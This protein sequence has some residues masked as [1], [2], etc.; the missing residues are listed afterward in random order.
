MST[1]YV[2]IDRETPMLLPP[3]LRDW[4]PE[5][6]LVNFI[7]EAVAMLPL[8][9]FRVN[10]RGSGN[11]QY[12]PS[13]MLSLLI[14]CYATG[15]MGSRQIEAA[16]YTDV[17]VRYI[18][19][20]HAHPDHDTIC[21][22]RRKNGKLFEDSFVKVLAYAQE[23]GV[24]KKR[25]GVSV[26]GTKIQANASKHAAVSY[27]RAG[28]MIAQLEM[29]VQELIARAEAA[30]RTPVPEALKVPEE[31]ARRQVRQA[32]LAEAR[33]VIEA[34]FEEKRQEQ[35]S[36]YEAKQAQR[37]TRRAQ[38]QP[39]RGREPQ[40]PPTAPEAGAQYNFT[41]PESRIM[42]AGNGD[43]FEQAYNAQAVVDT[44]GSMLVLGA[45]VTEQANDK[46]QLV[47]TVQ[48][49]APVVRDV[50]EVL[51]DSGFF[52]E[53]AV[54]QI[55]ANEGPTVYAAMDKQ[56]HHRT[57]ADLVPKADPPVPSAD[58]SMKEKMR[59][60]LQTASGKAKYALRKQTV[61]PVFGII[62]AVMGFRR[63]LL[64][65]KIKVSLEWTLVTLAYN[66][67]RLFRLV[68]RASVPG[69]SWIARPAA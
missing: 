59:H 3:D 52:S 25:G 35:Q 69:G 56:G 46:E 40:P 62:K 60:R 12:P 48:S 54:V 5:G 41:D 58:A 21:E 9:G 31:I 6:H 15:R 68:Q 27:Q 36:E 10:Q 44:E 42:K 47:P 29:E 13:M 39:M 18:C 20:G 19:G 16:T 4:L 2:N 8:H 32:K 11:D 22:F 49:M 38:G 43:H 28:E 45:R 65:G 7:L 14:Y 23:L 17:A 26:D 63:F 66:F 50:T 34:R 67:K 1:H 64:R 33:A 53:T 51:A 24:L 37:E 30:D 57:V 61:E 55:E